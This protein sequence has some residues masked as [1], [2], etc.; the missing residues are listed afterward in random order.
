M[1]T[2]QIG[3][4]EVG[5][6]AHLG[7][8]LEPEL[9][10]MGIRD[11]RPGRIAVDLEGRIACVVGWGSG[12]VIDLARP[13]DAL[14]TQ[15]GQIRGGPAGLDLARPP[16]GTARDHEPFGTCHRDVD[17]PEVLVSAVHLAGIDERRVVLRGVPGQMWQG[18][19]VTAYREGHG[20]GILGPS[21]DPTSAGEHPLSER[22]QHDDGELQPLRLVH[23]HELDTPRHGRTIERGYLIEARGEGEPAEERAHMG[24]TLD[25]GEGGDEIDESGEP[26][27][28][29]HPQE[30]GSGGHLDIE[31]RHTDDTVDQ[32]GQR[33]TDPAADRPNLR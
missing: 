27:G 24:L 7:G 9:K 32:I 30:F 28:T 20:L 11:R 8:D 26:L 13:R 10:G 31:P 33:V 5:V 18:F 29:V 22:G 3:H 12:P 21:G 25:I 14:I 19:A 16:P 23:G 17:Q 6:L 4:R 2:A 1:L 15:G